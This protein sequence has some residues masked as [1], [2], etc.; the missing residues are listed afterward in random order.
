MNKQ[1]YDVV[2]DMNYL[3]YCDYLQ[4]KYGIG[5]C[6]YMNSDFKKKN[7]KKLS[8]T[9][10]GLVV[11]HKMEDRMI[12]LSTPAYA[13]MG[14]IE[15]QKAENLIYCDYLEHLLLHI[16]IC[17]NPSEDRI[18]GY[19]VGIGGVINFLV[20]ELNDVYSG[21]V[22]KQ[23][24]R[25]NCY[26]KVRDDEEVYL[27]L[28]EKYIKGQG[29]EFDE[30]TLERSYNERYGYWSSEKNREIF[31]KIRKITKSSKKKQGGISKHLYHAHTLLA[32]GF[33]QG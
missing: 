29:K 17:E 5:R 23:Q 13:K 25:E 28:L 19:A 9:S 16:L 3:E 1:E 4:N 11:H 20:P 7:P 2:K 27:C 6:D 14:P 24:W 21:W 30:K 32:A 31:K 26:N 15:W 18:E 10:E 33:K 8:R 12:M 22:S